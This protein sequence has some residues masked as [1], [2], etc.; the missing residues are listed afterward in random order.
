MYKAVLITDGVYDSI[1]GFY[2]DVF[3]EP[4]KR[5]IIEFS[6]QRPSVSESDAGIRIVSKLR[7]FKKRKS[8][9]SGS[10]PPSFLRENETNLLE[11]TDHYIFEKILQYRTRKYVREY[12]IPPNSRIDFETTN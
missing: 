11:I 6:P 1:I 3:L 12:N 5:C 7:Q 9:V 8:F 10:D 4:M 2:N